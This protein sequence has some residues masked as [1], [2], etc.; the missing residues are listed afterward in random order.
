M[1]NIA[2]ASRC[3]VLRLRHAFPM[4]PTLKLHVMGEEGGGGQQASC[5]ANLPQVLA[6][7]HTNH[8]FCCIYS[9]YVTVT[10]AS[11]IRPGQKSVTL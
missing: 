11:K 5:L 2:T 1:S 8:M 9:C 7:F 3:L 10:V 4:C 6:S